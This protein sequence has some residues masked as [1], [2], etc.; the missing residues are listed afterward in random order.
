MSFYQDE[1]T[2]YQL[3]TEIWL[4]IEEFDIAYVTLGIFIFYAY[5]QIYFN[6][7][8]L[9]KTSL[10]NMIIS[11]IL[12]IT[13]IIGKSYKIDNTLNIIFATPAQTIKFILISIGYYLIFYALLKKLSSIHLKKYFQKK[14]PNDSKFKKI[15]NKYQIPIAIIV[16][17]LGWL[18]YIIFYFPGASTGDTFDCLSQYFHQDN[19]W[20]IDSINLINEEVYINKHHPPLFT[21]VLGLI[22]ELGNKLSSFTLGAFIYTILQITLLMI[23]FCFMIHYMKK[24]QIPLWIRMISVLFIAFTPTIAA[25]AITAVKDTPSAIFTLL[26]TIFLIQIVRNYDSI[27]KNKKR[28]WILIIVMLLVMMLRNNGIFTILL[29]FPFLITIYQDKWKKIM[30]ILLICLSIFGIYDKIILP[31]Y[32]I[33][34]GSIKEVLTIPF[35]QLA[36]VVCYNSEQIGEKDKEIINKV[37]NYESMLNSYSPNLAD[38]I[39]DTF[40]KDATQEEIKEFF[41]VWWKYFKKYPIVYIE[42]IINSTYGYFF[43]EVGEEYATL[44]VDSRVG[45]GTYFNILAKSE[46]KDQR[47]ILHQINLL[48]AKIPMTC[49]LNHVAFYDWFLIFSGIYIIK[50]K[51]YRYLIPLTPLLSVLLVCIASPINGSFRYILPIVFSLPIIFTVD[52]FVYIESD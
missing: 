10:I 11:I 48:L 51:K 7:T 44:A 38:S 31:A 34:D 6:G 52:Y 21:I 28:I 22:F 2:I 27:L 43:P 36:R 49:L 5:F 9:T 26:Y 23:I 16:I 40:K 13:I 29:S 35:M 33:T 12:T 20:S 45:E 1:N 37:L 46:Y 3:A 47:K 50:K 39:K 24:N 18:P 32:D 25:H 15:I 8:K 42:S 4:S 17:L 41:G 19:S 14:K 30:L